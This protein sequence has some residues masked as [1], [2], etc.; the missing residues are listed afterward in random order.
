MLQTGD[1]AMF[2]RAIDE[3]ERQAENQQWLALDLL[4]YMYLAVLDGY[5][6][7]YDD[8][9]HKQAASRLRSIANRFN[10]YRVHNHGNKPPPNFYRPRERSVGQYAFHLVYLLESRGMIRWF[11]QQ[12]TPTEQTYDQAHDLKFKFTPY[13]FTVD[14]VHAARQRAIKHLYDPDRM[15][16][17]LLPTYHLKDLNVGTLQYSRNS[18]KAQEIIHEA[19][20]H[21]LVCWAM[22]AGGESFQDPRLFRRINWVLTSDTPYAFD[23]SM[24]LQMLAQMP[25]DQW[26]RWIDR[27][28]DW[29]LGALSNKGNWPNKY[30]GESNDTWGNHASGAYGVLGLWAAEQS[31]ANVPL[32]AWRA[33]DAHWRKTQQ[34]TPDGEPAGWAV[35]MFNVD[36]GEEQDDNDD[37]ENAFQN[38]VSGPMTAAGVATLTLTERYIYGP[39]RTNPDEQNVSKSLRKGIDWLDNRFALDN[40]DPSADWFYY[41]WTM[42]RVGQATGYRTFNGVDWFREVTAEILN[43]Q[44]DET[45][46]WTDPSGQQG[47]LVSTGFALL[48]L[49]NSYAPLAVSKIRFDGEWNNRPHDIWNFVEHASDQYEVR[50]SWQIVELDQPVYQLIESPMLFLATDEGFEL[51]TEEVDQLRAYIDA[52]GM[53]V[54]NPDQPGAEVAR[55]FKNL[56]QTLYPDLQMQDVSTD[57]P[58]YSVHQKLRPNVRMKMMSNGIRPLIVQFTRDI[59]EG[60]QKNEVGRSESFV[61]LSNLYLYTI[62]LNPRRTRLDS[63]YL[64]P[65][66]DVQTV[67]TIKVAR[68]THNGQHNP[69]P[70]ALPQLKAMMR[71]QHA[72]NVQLSTVAPNELSDQ[73]VA[74]L[75]T[76]GDAE[77]TDTQA[78]SIRRWLENGGTLWVDAAGGA[79][80]AAENARSLVRKIMPDAAPTPLQS[81]SPIISGRGLH[82]GYN[83]RRIQYRYYALREM[84]PVTS[85]RLQTIRINDRPAIIYSP[86]DITAGL[87]GA[88]HW[89]VFG[90]TIRSA[91]RL[92]ANSLMHALDHRMAN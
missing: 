24:R 73:R 31:G 55:S 49:S 2:A 64:V 56:T 85:P 70:A 90:Y 54:L 57:H 89:G 45:G 66:T 47:P 58:I 76:L 39:E 9:T 52:G 16:D 20:N 38:R 83:N 34:Q 71:R 59:G 23:R 72:T 91:R 67:N 79:K 82:D 10:E 62:G 13:N 25:T 53:L 44:D 63:D 14:D 32:S 29:I 46:L 61:A 4:R 7:L 42:Q 17:R 3:V 28:T 36:R 18:V 33:V 8:A 12:V 75:T 26:R 35:N 84:G 37:E 68:L 78:D 87:A 60:L 74:F 15:R 19:G 22:L 11:Q 88:E 21:A 50:T 51:S 80:N 27:D 92:V 48:Y 30:I 41:M 5:V 65:G 1:N 86:E 40:S 43:R 69:E 6:L 77:L 81:L